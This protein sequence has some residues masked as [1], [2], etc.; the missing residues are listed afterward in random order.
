MHHSVISVGVKDCE[1][2]GQIMVLPPVC[3]IRSL[4]GDPQTE[5]QRSWTQLLLQVP[6]P[7]ASLVQL[8]HPASLSDLSPF[9][10]SFLGATC[11]AHATGDGSHPKHVAC[12]RKGAK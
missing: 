11:H 7:K 6:D 5:S 4:W 9:Q 12:N 2:V 1:S 3:L 10:W 8:F